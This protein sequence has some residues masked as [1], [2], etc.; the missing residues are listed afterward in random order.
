M[1]Y[2]VTFK[3]YTLCTSVYTFFTQLDQVQSCHPYCVLGHK[4]QS[5]HGTCYSEN[6]RQQAHSA[7]S[8]WLTGEEINAHGA[9]HGVQ[10]AYQAEDDET[11][12]FSSA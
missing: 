12:E 1:Q 9:V 3:G 7:A 11:V 4:I 10:A 8:K 2:S 5:F 6:L